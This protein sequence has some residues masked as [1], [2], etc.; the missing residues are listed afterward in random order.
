M[1]FEQD[2]NL[3]TYLREV[4][5]YPLLKFKEELELGK[6]AREGS[7]EAAEKLTN[8]NLRLV[9]SIAKKIRAEYGTDLLED[10]ALRLTE[11]FG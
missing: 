6:R 3:K 9:I 11:G 2:S 1:Y 7:R 4:K 5:K 10:L 8:C